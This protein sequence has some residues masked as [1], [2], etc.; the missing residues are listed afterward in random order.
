MKK[1]FKCLTIMLVIC[2]ISIPY[3]NI[4]AYDYDFTK[5]YINH[6]I[7]EICGEIVAI[8]KEFYAGDHVQKGDFVFNGYVIIEG[9]M[10]EGDCIELAN[11]ISICPQS[12]Y[13]KEYCKPI[14]FYVY[15]ENGTPIS[16]IEKPIEEFNNIKINLR[17]LYYID[18]G[19]ETIISEFHYYV[20]NGLRWYELP[21][22]KKI[23]SLNNEV[24]KGYISCN[25][26][27]PA[28]GLNKI[29]FIFKLDDSSS[30]S[31]DYVNYLEGIELIFRL[32]E[33]KYVKST[34][35]S[36]YYS[37]TNND[38]NKVLEYK[39]DDGKW[40]SKA[41]FDKLEPNTKHTLSIRVK[42]T[43]DHKASKVIKVSIKTKKK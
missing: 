39:L 5:G 2:G 12:W 21:L 22:H 38:T 15:N 25:V 31:E 42:K 4:Y 40:C 7:D 1:I 11:D 3:T 41:K 23:Q 36:I 18:E 27:T 30:D 9:K 14:I 32:P 29:D 16:S 20:G 17:P 34:S 26:D 19:K 33:K 24:M 10:Y 8:K 28:Y 35:T 13:G 37:D 43:S 6:E